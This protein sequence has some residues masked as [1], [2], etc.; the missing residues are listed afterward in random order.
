MAG[1]G[2]STISRTVAHELGQQGRLG[3]SCYFES[4][5]DDINSHGLL[6]GC[7]E[8]GKGLLLI[9]MV[10]AKPHLV[11]P[12][13]L[14]TR[15]VFDTLLEDYNNFTIIAHY[16]HD[17]YRYKRPHKRTSYITASNPYP[18]SAR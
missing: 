3:A 18:I 12:N 4:R 5:C 15:L 17:L 10:D 7:K 9:D 1:T 8:S 14:P 13:L 11:L 16:K 6:M 2:K